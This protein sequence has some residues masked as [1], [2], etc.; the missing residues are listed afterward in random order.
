MLNNLLQ[1]GTATSNTTSLFLG[2]ILFLIICVVILIKSSSG[3]N[4][5]QHD[6]PNTR[7]KA[8]GLCVRRIFYCILSQLVL[9]FLY[10]FLIGIKVGYGAST[11]SY[12]I[13]EFQQYSYWL[14][15]Y[16]GSLN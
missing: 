13:D 1:A 12:N 11:N 9:I 5:I 6:N 14:I 15:S 3:R 7:I 2:G 4:S 10:W 8:A 16:L